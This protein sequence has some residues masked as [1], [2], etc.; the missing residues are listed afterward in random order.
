MRPAAR[1]FGSLVLLTVG[2]AACSGGTTTEPSSTNPGTGSGTGSGS[3]SGT[4]G[5]GTTTSSSS[6]CLNGSYY[7]CSSSAD[8]QKCFDDFAP[9]N[10]RANSSK[11]STC[12]SG[13]GSS[14]GGGSGGGS[15]KKATGKAC[16]KNDECSGELCIVNSDNAPG[17]CSEPCTNFSTCPSFWGCDAV[18]SN[19]P[20]KVCHQK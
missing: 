20:G 7:E 8:A 12:S 5:G 19:Y 13:G 6:C 15:S 16:N 4:G 1:L 18:L 11:N 2:I 17:Y 14:G 10:C 3:G 9:G